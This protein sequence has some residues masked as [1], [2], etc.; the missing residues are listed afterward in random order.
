[1]NQ[2]HTVA[3]G[4]LNFPATIEEN[5]VERFIADP[6]HW[7]VAQLLPPFGGSGDK[8][9]NDMAIAFARGEFSLWD[10]AQMNIAMGYSISGFCELHSFGDLAIES[11]TITREGRTFRGIDRIAARNLKVEISHQD[12]ADL[13]RSVMVGQIW[14]HTKSGGIYYVYS[15]AFNTITDETDVY[16]VDARKIETG[17]EAV[18]GGMEFTRQEENNPKSFLSNNDDG[19][20][21]FVRLA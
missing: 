15:K 21:R 16:Y 12:V 1:M 20:P 5:G 9:P 17:Y 6:D 11:K 14:Q 8:S 7:L 13:P 18:I 10:Y 3:V 4:G 2:L 19:T